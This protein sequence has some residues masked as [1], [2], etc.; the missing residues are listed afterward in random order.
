MR[1]TLDMV[2]DLLAASTIVYIERPLA[3]LLAMLLVV[4][5]LPDT[6][7]EIVVSCWWLISFATGT[8]VNQ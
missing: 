3:V 4:A 6:M 7:R 5:A 2:A 1:R 8:E